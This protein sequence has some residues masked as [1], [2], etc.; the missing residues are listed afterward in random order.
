MTT[1][2]EVA[3]PAAFPAPSVD[4]ERV[5]ANVAALC[6]TDCIEWLARVKRKKEHIIAAFADFEDIGAAEL[7]ARMKE[8][9][10]KQ[11]PHPSIE[12][13]LEDQ[14]TAYRP[15]V[16]TL[17]EAARLCKPDEA[18]KLVKHIPEYQPPTPAVI[19]EHDEAGATSSILAIAK[20]YPGSAL[21]TLINAAMQRDKTGMRFVFRPV[22]QPQKRV[23]DYA[24]DPDKMAEIAGAK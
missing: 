18:A 23:T 1:T 8:R 10:A 9:G 14:F 16:D 12:V 20:R 11:I 24:G 19:P 6:D 17:L 21:E 2:T 5:K 7:A 15:D 4:L 22:Q 13:A 3:L